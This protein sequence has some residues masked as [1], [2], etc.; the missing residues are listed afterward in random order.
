MIPSPPR[1]KKRLLAFGDSLT[2][3]FGLP[4]RSSFTA[5]LQRRLDSLGHKVRVDNHGISGDT[6]A[7]GLA[8]IDA[9]LRS[10]PD[11]VLLELGT[12][13]ALMGVPL[14]G[15]ERNLEGM[16]QS[17]LGLKC[18][19]LLAGVDLSPVLG[20]EEGSSLSRVYASLARQYDLILHPDFLAGV[21]GQPELTLMDGVHPS[22]QGVAAMVEAIL[23]PVVRLVSSKPS[24]E[25]S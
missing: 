14:P 21:V 10:K 3:G 13:D 19:T 17:C 2:A 5:Q 12:N 22:E 16:I 1:P 8:R 15:I 11:F 24:T 25:R 9:A 7:G 4:S 23:D 6:T 18:P 20:H